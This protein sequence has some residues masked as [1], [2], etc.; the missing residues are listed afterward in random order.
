[1]LR[2]TLKFFLYLLLVACAVTF[3][4]GN[5][6]LISVTLYPL[7]F[8]ISIPLFLF[9]IATIVIGM[10]IGWTIARLGMFKIAKAAKHAGERALAMEHELTALRHEKVLKQR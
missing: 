6:T 1:M 8:A 2:K 9:A 10:F 3:S 5:R 4:V 7:P